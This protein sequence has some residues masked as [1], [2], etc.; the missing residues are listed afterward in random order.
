MDIVNQITAIN[1]LFK[2]EKADKERLAKAHEQLQFQH[3]KLQRSCR[4]ERLEKQELMSCI[5]NMQMKCSEELNLLKSLDEAT[6]NLVTARQEHAEAAAS[7]AQCR[8]KCDVLEARNATLRE[9]LIATKSG[10]SD[11]IQAMGR[12]CEQALNSMKEKL[13][14]AEDQT[15]T[16]TNMLQE[17]HRQQASL[18][19]PHYG[20]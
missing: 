7:A 18:A 13:A 9:E 20:N 11:T 8:N 16:V 17:Q 4:L 14:A 19:S 2:K 6:K 3:A 10:S 5:D 1:T 12:K 15:K